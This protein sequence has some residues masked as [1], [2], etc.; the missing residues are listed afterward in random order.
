[1]NIPISLDSWPVLLAVVALVILAVALVGE[2][3]L[4]ALNVWSRRSRRSVRNVAA[5]P[6]SH[7]E[8]YDWSI[9][10]L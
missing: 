9:Q 4:Q 1:M 3:L 6:T 8:L 10:G 5:R 2:I 7:T